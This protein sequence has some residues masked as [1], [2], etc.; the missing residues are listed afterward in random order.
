MPRL[1]LL[2]G[3]FYLRVSWT[4]TDVIWEVPTPSAYVRKAVFLS[5]DLC[6]L[7]RKLC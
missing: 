4:G 1:G 6:A 7:I 3:N 2:A 5:T